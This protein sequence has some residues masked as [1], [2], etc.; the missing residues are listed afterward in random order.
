MFLKN[1]FFFLFLVGWFIPF[2]FEDNKLSKVEIC[3]PNL[4]IVEYKKEIHGN[5]LRLKENLT[6]LKVN[7][8]VILKQGEDR[9]F[10]KVRNIEYKKENELE[11]M[12][13]LDTL[14]LVETK[15]NEES[16]QRIVMVVNTGKLVEN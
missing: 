5:V 15:T 8:Q 3:I 12:D 13:T 1:S 10:Y 4:N 6:N 7:D 14:Y 11:N 2:S 16:L 9:Y